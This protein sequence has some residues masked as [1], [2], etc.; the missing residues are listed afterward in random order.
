[1]SGTGLMVLL[2]SSFVA[3]GH[4]EW[5][6]EVGEKRKRRRR[7]KRDEKRRHRICVGER[8][9]EVSATFFKGK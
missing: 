6:S 7:E 3:S 2:I 9:I 4:G 1:M 5:E 8:D